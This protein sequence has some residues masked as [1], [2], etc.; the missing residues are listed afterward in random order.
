MIVNLNAC[1]CSDNFFEG[2]HKFIVKRPPTPDVYLGPRRSV[3]YLASLR[4]MPAGVDDQHNSVMPKR[5]IHCSKNQFRL[6]S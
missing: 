4:E 3:H 2:G 1:L 5:I 6:M